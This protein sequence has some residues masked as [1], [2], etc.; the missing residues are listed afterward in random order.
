M[1]TNKN[2]IVRI[3]LIMNQIKI[4]SLNVNGME[5]GM[6]RRK[7]FMYAK[8]KMPTI[9]MFQETHSNI[10]CESL[11]NTE[12]GSQMIFSHGETNSRGV[13]IAMYN[14]KDIQILKISRDSRGRYLIIDI[15]KDDSKMT[16][17]NLYV[18]NEDDPDFFMDIFE[19]Q[20]HH[21]NSNIVIGGDFNLV[22][23]VSK[24]CNNPNRCN[25]M[26]AL[27]IIKLF[28]NELMLE[29]IHRIKYPEA[30]IYTWCR[31]RPIYVAS[32]IDFFLV[33]YGLLNNI[34]CKIVP[35]FSTDKH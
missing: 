24:D 32:R 14:A 9:V 17:I 33:N 6:K 19:T 8:T 21:D 2:C 4:I 20:S 35:G 18:P 15:Q 16:L 26:K 22:M 12:W 25:N 31:R 27:Q 11:W 7:I 5:N 10:E 3:K 34:S 30:R 28:M 23:D 13:M 29:D 1:Y